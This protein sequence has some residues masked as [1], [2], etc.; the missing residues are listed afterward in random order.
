MDE[1]K[2]NMMVKEASVKYFRDNFA[3]IIDEVAETKRPYAITRYGRIKSYVVPKSM[4][5]KYFRKFDKSA[6]K[7]KKEKETQKALDEFYGIWKDRKE[8]D[9]S[10]AYVRKLRE[11]PDLLFYKLDE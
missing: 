1:E 5:D 3:E 9:D 11:N 2:E 4:Y 7:S 10:V 8:M 6:K